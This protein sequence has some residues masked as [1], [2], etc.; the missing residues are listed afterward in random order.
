[1][2]ELK[3]RIWCHAPKTFEYFTVYDY[4][5]GIAGGVSTPDQYT[6]F[7]DV[8]GKEI[9]EGDIVEGW[10]KPFPMNADIGLK[11]KHTVHWT[12]EGRWSL[13]KIP[14]HGLMYDYE[15]VGNVYEN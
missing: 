8:N 5:Q 6:G 13:S 7:K 3:F 4:P 10:V 2:R 14:I 15:I 1:M 12:P 11:H 9:Y